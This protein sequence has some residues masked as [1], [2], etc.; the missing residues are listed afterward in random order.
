MTEVQLS[1]LQEDPYFSKMQDIELNTLDVPEMQTLV[2]SIK[3]NNILN[4]YGQDLPPTINKDNLDST[5]DSLEHVKQYI[6]Q[7]VVNPNR[8]DGGKKR[9][10]TRRLSAH[11]KR[12][13]RGKKTRRR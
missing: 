2:T 9:R 13:R 1:Q 6:F 8:F 3:T 7:N 4:K 12:K 10:K 11:M 5:R